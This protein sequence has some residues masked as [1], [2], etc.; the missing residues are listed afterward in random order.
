MSGKRASSDL[1]D[2]N[3]FTRPEWAVEEARRL[4]RMG[5]TFYVW[6]LRDGL[7][8]WTAIPA[9][10]GGRYVGATLVQTEIA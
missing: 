9:P 10:E 6:R 1:F 4:L 3:L 2:M 5:A 7:Y 8:D